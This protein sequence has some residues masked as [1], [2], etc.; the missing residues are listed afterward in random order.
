MILL[1]VLL[2]GCMPTQTNQ[3]QGTQNYADANASYVGEWTAGFG[4]GLTALKINKDGMVKVCSSNPA[5]M[6]MNGKVFE[7]N[8]RILIIFENGWLYKV[9]DMNV[10]YFMADSAR[11][12]ATQPGT[13]RLKFN[14][15]QVP[16]E[17]IELFEKFE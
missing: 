15:G 9:Y 2:S 16:E 12:T 8:G 13:Q 1:V 17:C 5:A 10:D 11:Q 14:A 3:Y 7:K 6:G 4:E